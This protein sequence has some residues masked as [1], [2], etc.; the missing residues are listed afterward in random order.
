MPR[1]LLSA[2]GIEAA[3]KTATEEANA[4]NTRVKIRDGNNLLLI[5]RPGGGAS[6]VLQYRL[7]G[8]RKA[9]TL[10]PWPTV[11]LKVARELAE[12]ARVQ[13]LRGVDPVQAKAAEREAQAAKADTVRQM[14][15]DW[16]AVQR[17]SDVY[18]G[19]I[20]AAFAK[21]VL[22]VIGAMSP[23]AVT[24]RDILTILRAIEKRDALV[25]LRRVRMWLKQLWEF[26]LDDGER[27][28]SSPVPTGHLRSFLA[29]DAGKMPA[30]TDA[31]EVAGLMN[32][33]RGYDRPVVR[34]ALLL[35]AYLWQRPTE[36]RE[37]TWD[38]F[39]LDGA[40]WQLSEDRMK[41][42]RDHWVPLPTQAVELLR[43][44]QGVVGNVGWLFPG[45]G[46]GK[47]LSD[48]TLGKALD[49]M[50]FKGKHSP[51]GFR[52][53]ARTICEEV[54]KEEAKVLEKHLAH[55][56]PDKVA[57]AYNR[58]QYWD[59]RVAMVQRWADWLDAQR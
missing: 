54:L 31:S 1:E 53:M 35:S 8:D 23:R 51:H 2:R 41:M 29:P 30:I 20:E 44:H 33:I 19:N 45:R 42:E 18:R 34:T 40:R 5:V 3:L 49:A 12:D 21:D 6:W 24:R 50:G 15:Q 16:M 11:T 17:V 36:I 38:E 58:A 22:P 37:A 10:G 9:L 47:P 4:K 59:E 57:R 48:G 28:E 26:G 32:A 7:A 27:V 56:L 39:D 13:V 46:P 55:E 25:M 52:A 14:Y 43:R